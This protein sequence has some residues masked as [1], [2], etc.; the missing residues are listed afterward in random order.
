[1]DPRI[2]KIRRPGAVAG[3]G[4]LA[5][6]AAVI[7][8]IMVVTGCGSQASNGVSLGRGTSLANG[9]GTGGSASDPLK[10]SRPH[11]RAHHAAPRHTH[12]ATQSAATGAPT[13]P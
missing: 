6:L 3:G 9:T 10:S 5:A 2:R 13:T 1:M 8:V 11:P 12:Q 7:G 4:L